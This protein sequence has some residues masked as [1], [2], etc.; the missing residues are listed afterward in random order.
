VYDF[1]S[2]LEPDAWGLGITSA[3]VAWCQE[4]LRQTAGEHPTDRRSWF[5]TNVFDGD[6]ELEGVLRARG[7][8]AVRWDAEM[9][10]ETMDGLPAVPGLPA[11]Y[12]IRPVAAEDMATVHEAVVASFREH[13]GEHAEGEGADGLRDWIEDPAFELGLVT[14]VWAGDQPAACVSSQVQADPDGRPR[15]YVD[16][17]STHPDHRRLGLARAALADNLHR[18]AAR[19]VESAYLGVDTDNQNRAFALY[20]DAGFRK[21][22]GTASYRK[23]FTAET[24]T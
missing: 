1:T 17:V 20:E 24:T 21:V 4:R 5:A 15:A 10:R 16:G 3:L 23:P 9:L 7:F 13:W 18:L 14:V 12:E 19:G 22:T 6:V 2:V 8:E 11:G